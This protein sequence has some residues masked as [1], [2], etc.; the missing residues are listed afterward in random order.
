MA[1]IEDLVDEIA[2]PALREHWMTATERTQSLLDA[3]WLGALDNE[4]NG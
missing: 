4:K 3:A 2:D 1:K